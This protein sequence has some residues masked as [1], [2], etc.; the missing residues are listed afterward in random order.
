MSRRARIPLG[1]CTMSVVTQNAGP[2]YATRDESTRA[3]VAG[4]FMATV[5]A[6]AR[7]L[8]ADFPATDFAMPTIYGT[9]AASVILAP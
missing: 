5:V 1:S 4:S 7:G 6:F 9:Q 8:L 2:L 3:F